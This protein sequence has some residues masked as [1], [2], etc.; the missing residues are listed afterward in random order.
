[1]LRWRD[2]LRSGWQR[3]RP[4]WGKG[5]R[6]RAEQC[7]AYDRRHLMAQAKHIAFAI[8]MNAVGQQDEIAIIRRIDPESCSGKAGVAKGGEPIESLAANPRIKCIDIK[9]I[10]SMRGSFNAIGLLVQRRPRHWPG[11]DPF[12]NR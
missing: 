9:T 12:P 4:S 8:R 6:S 11:L 3:R 1:R 7:F 2:C 10:G 5:G